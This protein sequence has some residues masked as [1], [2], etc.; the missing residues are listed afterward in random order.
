MGR[1]ILFITTDQQRYDALGCNG[2][3]VA[4]TPVA[5]SLAA[6]GINYRRAYNQNTVCMPARSTMITGQYVRTHGVFANGVPLPLDAPSVAAWLHDRAGYRTALIGKAHFEP[7]FDLA[8][9]WAENRMGREGTHGPHRGFDFMELAMHGPMASFHYSRWLRENYPSEVGG[10]VTMLAGS[11]GGDSGA[12]E[13]AYNPIP[14]EHYHTDWVAD[15]TIAYLR[16]LAPGDDWFVWMSFP[17]PH[18]P[19]DPPAAEARRIN[20]RDLDLPPGHPGSREKIEKIL[21]AKPRHW[22]DWYQ[23]RFRNEEGGPWNFVPCQMTHDQVREINAL[24]HVKNELIDQACGRVLAAVAER[25]WDADT[26][27]FFTSDHGELQGDFGLL[28]KGPY[29][30]DALMRVP[31]IWR[32]AP[33]AKL[34]AAEVA[35]PVGHLDLAPTFCAIA[36]APVPAGCRVPRCRPPPARRASVQSPNG[37]ANSHSSGCICGASFPT[38]S[39]A[40]CTSL[41]P[42]TSATTSRPRTRRCA[43]RLLCPDIRYDGTEGELYNLREDPLQWRNLWNDAGYLRLKSDLIADLYDHLPPERTPRLTVDAPA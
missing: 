9:R 16:M 31:L 40:P 20:W 33:S 29:H 18:H 37:T 7:M 28:F 27:V 24:V 25:G 43:S 39:S 41:R 42:A 38:V 3:R 1:K 17:D 35:E 6:A 19:W 11:V 13:V 26:D 15:R 22:L 21:A 36:G 2:G 23:G 8:G 10:F 5:D 4:R 34:P 30:V 32:P 14:R 12:P